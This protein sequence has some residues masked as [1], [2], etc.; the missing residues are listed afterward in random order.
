[1]TAFSRT[2][3]N[4]VLRKPQRGH[5]ERDEVYAILDAAL[6]CHVGFV[7]DG[8]PYVIPTLHA[9][10]GDTLLLHGSSA[11]RMIKH[12]GAGGA[13]C[14]SATLV[15]GIVLARS[16]FN[17]SI[18]YRS[19]AL[20][21]AGQLISDPD[22][23]LAAL[24][25]FTERMLPGR[26]DDV[27]LPNRKEF[28][29]TGIVAVPIESASAKVRVGPPLDEPEDLELP[30]WAGVLPLRQV[31]DAPVADESVPPG[32]TMPVYLEEYVARQRELERVA[33][34]GD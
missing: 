5:Y 12:V 27:R 2:R 3:R 30:I 16:V 18:N 1:M 4:K 25:R 19:V 8:Q 22:E 11:S 17:H 20:Y 7:L 34:A 9:R 23:K 21:G 10:D 26:W 29:A 15:D 14:V 24:A 13:V 28:K 33:V 6:V 32:F 31:M